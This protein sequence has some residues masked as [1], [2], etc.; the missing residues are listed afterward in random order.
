[1]QLVF[2]YSDLSSTLQ[3]DL[4]IPPL[5]YYQVKQLASS[6]FWLTNIHKDSIPGQIYAFKYLERVLVQNRD[7]W[8]P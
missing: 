7:V 1:M 6:H 4:G 5:V 2:R 3:A 8:I